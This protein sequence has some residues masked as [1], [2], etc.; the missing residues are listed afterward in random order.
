[1]STQLARADLQHTRELALLCFDGFSDAV[2][3][4]DQLGVRA[5]H[6]VA[7]GVNHLCHKRLRLAEKASVA[8]AAAQNL[9]EHVA[10]AFVGGVDFV[11]YEEGCGAGVVGDD[12][13]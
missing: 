6:F 9:A 8:N 3:V 7:D 10:A 12:S 2:G 4:V 5:A 11:R 1:L 13:Q